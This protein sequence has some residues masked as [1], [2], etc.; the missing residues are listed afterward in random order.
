MFSDAWFRDIK[1]WGIEIKFKYFSEKE[2]FSRNH[3]TSEGAVSH[4]VLY[5]QHHL[6]VSF[7]AYNYFEQLPINLCSA[8]NTFYLYQLSVVRYQVSFHAF[9]F[10]FSVDETIVSSAFNV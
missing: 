9:K 6:Q 8:F 5:Y 4:H 3:V 7:C 2:L 1:F 10:L